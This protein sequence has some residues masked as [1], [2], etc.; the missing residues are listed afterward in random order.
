MKRVILVCAVAVL[1][2]SA[3]RAP[4]AGTFQNG[5]SYAYDYEIVSNGERLKGTIY[6]E[7]TLYGFC[8]TGCRL[9]LTQTGQTI[10]MQPDDYII[11]DNG[12]MKEKP[13]D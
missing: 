10:Y 4:L 7:S 9:T 6:D 13:A 1:C 12:V 8:D 3:A 11:I 2:L 5:D